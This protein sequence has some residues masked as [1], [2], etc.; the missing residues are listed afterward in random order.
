MPGCIGSFGQSLVVAVE[1]S[2]EILVAVDFS[3][4]FLLWL[5]NFVL[6]IF[7]V[8]AGN[9]SSCIVSVSSIFFFISV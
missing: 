3:L 6:V 9:I 7:V 5:L 4:K 2:I 8:V 1:F